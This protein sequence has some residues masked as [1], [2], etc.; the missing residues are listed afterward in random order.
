[1]THGKC[2]LLIFS[3]F[4]VTMLDAQKTVSNNSPLIYIDHGVLRYTTDHK[5]AAFFGVNYTV[6]FA[7]SYRAHKALHVDVKKAIQEDVYHFARLGLDAFRVHVWDT[8]ISDTLGNLLANEHL[9]LFDFLLAELEKRNIK[10]IVTPVAFW[11]NGYPQKDEATPGFSAKYGKLGTT[12]NDTAIQATENYLQQFLKHVNPYTKKSYTHDANIIAAE[13]NNEPRHTGSKE[14]VIHYIDRLAASIKGAGWH[15]PVFYNISENPAYAGAVAASVAD[16]FSFQ[17]YPT[18]LVSGHTLYENF[19]PHVDSYPIPFKDSLPAFLHKPLMVYEFDAADVMRPIMYPA[20]AK[21]FRQ[22]GFQWA[23]QFAYDPLHL[24]YANT[25]YQTHYLNLAY[26]PS[27]AISLMIASEVFHTLPKKEKYGT[28][29]VDSVFDV[30]RVSYQSALS[31]MNSNDKFYYSNNTTT[32]PKNENMLQ[33]IAGVGS[34]ALVQY[35]GT[36]AYFLDKLQTGIWRLEVMP[37]AVPVRDRFERASPDKTVTAIAWNKNTFIINLHELGENFKIQ[38]L[39]EGNDYTGTA[40]GTQCIL[41]PGTYLLTIKNR[42]YDI[43]NLHSGT[44]GLQEFVA[45]PPSVLP[46]MV[47]HKPVDEVTAGKSFNIHA[48]IFRA[49]SAT[50]Y[51]QIMRLGEWGVKNIPM[52][53][54]SGFE[55]IAAVP[56]EWVVPGQL[57]YRIIIQKNKHFTVYPGNTHQ[58]P[59]AWDNYH[60]ET[61]KTNVVKDSAFEIYNPYTDQDIFFYDATQNYYRPKYIP[62]T[63]LGS[64]TIDIPINGNNK[65]NFFA[66]QHTLTNKIRGRFNE[67][68]EFKKISIEAGTDMPDTAMLKL[69]LI[70]K[71]AAAFSATIPVSGHLRE[72]IIPINEF[73]KDSFLLLP[74]PYP[75]FQPLWFGNVNTNDILQMQEVE[76]IQ[77]IIYPLLQNKNSFNVRIGK[78]RLVK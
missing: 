46:V 76:R 70:T 57:Q 32:Q 10:I 69:L 11:G 78:I 36:G 30:F 53:P 43:S 41:S 24:A 34:S 25:E 39:N 5:E 17:W 22:A 49:D 75:Q 21:S 47:K 3:F 67:M 52:Q 20:M 54:V 4:I 14:A 63:G 13:I 2:F 50:I 40:D 61:W 15:K 68:E 8:E 66:I 56:E 45:P 44:I 18:G 27:K 1:M 58:E 60:T 16:G 42:K 19:L 28:Y 23:T 38:G 65:D 6:P 62:H 35:N 9:D 33:H 48:T 37:D 31:E 77:C 64:M 74:R 26:T 72:I 7:Y 55:Y 12:T 59:F 73:Q 71:N 29:P 51:V